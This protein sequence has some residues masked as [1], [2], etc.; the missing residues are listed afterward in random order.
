M[1]R[2]LAR[3]YTEKVTLNFKVLPPAAAAAAAPASQSSHALTD[4]LTNAWQFLL[5]LKASKQTKLIKVRNFPHSPAATEKNGE[6][7]AI[8]GVKL[9]QSF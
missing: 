2:L 5:M 9:S 6:T 1:C 8:D 7:L 4:C 3:V